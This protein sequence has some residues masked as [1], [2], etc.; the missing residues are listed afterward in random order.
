MLNGG[1]ESSV[2]RALA[3][4]RRAGFALRRLVIVLRSTSVRL[5]LGYAVL[6]AT[7]SLFMVAF[8]WWRTAGYLDLQ[9]DAVIAANAREITDQL[10]DFGL[11]GAIEAIHERVAESPDGRSVYLLANRQLQPL[12]GNLPAWPAAA[13]PKPGSYQVEILRD[14]QWRAMRLL[15]V[16][17]PDG[18]NLL[19]GR[20]VEDRAE[21]RAL[22]VDGLFWAAGTALLLAIGGGILMRRAVLRRV[23]MIND[24]ASAIVRGD[25]TQ[26]IPTRET[27]DAFDQLAQTINRMLQQ[28]HKLVEGVRNTANAIAHDLRTPLAELRARLEELLR[29]RPAREVTYEE[30]HKAVGDIDRVIAVF[31]ALLRLAEIDSGARRSGFRRVELADLVTE[32]AELYAPVIEEEDGVFAVEAEGGL[33][34]TGDPYLLAQAVGNLVDNAVKYA[35]PHGE[36]NLRIARYGDGQIEI[37]VADNGPGIP[38][39]DKPRVTERFY[40]CEASCATAGIGLGLSLVEA[41]ARLHDGSLTLADNHPG[42]KASLKLPEAP[43]LPKRDAATGV[44]ATECFPAA[45]EATP[46]FLYKN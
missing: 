19:V 22:I 35:P 45:A 5:G 7:S 39:A 1:L 11:S 21:L 38:D 13:S 33:M 20:D 27:A 18:L 14:G 16:A 31:N 32:I 37:V 25:L 34:V 2:F 42:L 30:I 4:A 36:V 6:F 10:R 29:T 43:A 3:E 44:G 12:A 40:R 28:I 9:A 41:V 46:G 15:R 8:L 17:L 26:R 24:T 23:E